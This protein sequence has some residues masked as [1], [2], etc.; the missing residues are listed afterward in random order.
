MRMQNQKVIEQLGYSSKEAKV[1]LASLRLGE[2]HVT[3]IAAKVQMPLSSVQLILDKLHDG[4][5]MNF[6]VMKRYKFWVATKPQ[7]LL[8]DLQTREEHIEEAMPKLKALRSI[9][10]DDRRLDKNHKE[11]V[12][13]FQMIA[14]A[15]P[16]SVLITNQDA[17]IEYVNDIWQKQFGYSP[18]EVLGQHTRMFQSGKTAPVVYERM[19]KELHANT[20]FQSDEIIDKRKDGTFFNLI[21][22]I[23]PVMHGNRTFYIQ[24]LDDI[25][26]KE[27][28]QTLHQ[29]FIKTTKVSMRT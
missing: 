10:C 1:Y 14:D 23:F 27:G 17:E 16:Q 11:S 28:V 3:D 7:Q 6:Y 2:S 9:D 8:K 5:L 12:A 24:I 15:S 18:E 26:G 20:L 13:V 4:G 21:T 29:S 19:W 25:T 22:T